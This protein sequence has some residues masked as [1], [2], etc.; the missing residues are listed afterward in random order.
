MSV[1]TK[2]RGIALGTSVAVGALVLLPALSA[3]AAVPTVAATTAATGI[4]VDNATS[5]S[6]NVAEVA[7]TSTGT[8]TW[9]A[10][11]DFTV[12]APAGSPTPAY[13]NAVIT[14]SLQNA[15]F[16]ASFGNLHDP[17]WRPSAGAPSSTREAGPSAWFNPNGAVRYR[18]GGTIAD[19]YRYTPSTPVSNSFDI[20]L[21]YDAAA[22]VYR[23][24]GA[25]IGPNGQT[26]SFDIESEEPVFQLYTL[27]GLGTSSSTPQLEQVVNVEF[28][29]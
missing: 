22:D 2:R 14:P 24:T 13:I 19:Q 23:I 3:A 25:A 26:Q 29:V 16:Y 18:T 28:D 9:D 20:E 15:G 17:N 11:V 21:E 8:G 27:G 10:T 1:L 4:V 7:T 12:T 6:G 5:L